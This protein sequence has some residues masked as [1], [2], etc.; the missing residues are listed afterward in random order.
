MRGENNPCTISSAA[1]PAPALVHSLALESSEHSELSEISKA[2]DAEMIKLKL[3]LLFCNI[4][5]KKKNE[6]G[7]FIVTIKQGCIQLHANVPMTAG[8][9]YFLRKKYQCW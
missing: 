3:D 2:L 7:V 8:D 9:E 4:L 1:S 6:G 5:E